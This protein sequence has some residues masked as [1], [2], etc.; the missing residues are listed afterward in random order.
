MRS[1]FQYLGHPLECPSSPDPT[2]PVP[3]FIGTPKRIELHHCFVTI[4]KPGGKSAFGTSSPITVS[5]L[6]NGTAYAFTVTATNSAGTGTASSASNS[7]TPT[8]PSTTISIVAGWNL[9]GNSYNTPIDVTSLLSDTSKI[10][11]VW[12]WLADKARWAFYAPTLSS[13]A[14]SDYV[15]TN[16]YDALSTI[17]GGEGFWVNA[18]QSFDLQ[19]PNGVQILATDFQSG[20][21]QQLKS[22]WSLIAMGDSKSP[23]NFNSSLSLTPLSS[24]TTISNITSLW[25]WQADGSKWYFYAPS[26]DASGQLINYT[27]NNGYLDFS[28]SQKTL[29]PGVGFWI[30]KP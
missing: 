17:V 19:M 29:T 6:T 2:I 21:A 24:G 14:L 1:N 11:A 8:L 16:G 10:T 9:I 3:P 26:L 30:N 15:S 13:Q 22:G 4:S 25:A 20:G 27:Q 5:G 28:T 23:S 18:K 7:V 12:K